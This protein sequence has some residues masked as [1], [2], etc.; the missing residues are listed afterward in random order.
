ME[1]KQW[2]VYLRRSLQI[3]GIIITADFDAEEADVAVADYVVAGVLKAAAAGTVGPVVSV[4]PVQ[5]PGPRGQGSRCP[6]RGPTEGVAVAAA[7]AVA[8]HCSS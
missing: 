1:V 8:V 7:V 6:G 5:R 4:G 3:R 2:G